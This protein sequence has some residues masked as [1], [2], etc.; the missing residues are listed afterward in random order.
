MWSLVDDD[1]AVCSIMHHSTAVDGL[2]DMGEVTASNLVDM[3]EE[4][5]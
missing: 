1:I 4:V 5:S 2:E 3:L